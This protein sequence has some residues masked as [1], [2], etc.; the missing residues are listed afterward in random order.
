VRRCELSPT[1][2]RCAFRVDE[3]MS[4]RAVRIYLRLWMAY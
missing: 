4:A 2:V 1:G 3:M